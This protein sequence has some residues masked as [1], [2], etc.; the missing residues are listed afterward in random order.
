MTY[1]YDA[2]SRVVMIIYIVLDFV[3]EQSDFARAGQL[4]LCAST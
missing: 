1:K 3:G 2:E 4:L